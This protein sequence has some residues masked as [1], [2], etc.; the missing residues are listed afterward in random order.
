MGNNLISL[1][2]YLRKISERTIRVCDPERKVF[3]NLTLNDQGDLVVDTRSSEGIPMRKIVDRNSKYLYDPKE[4]EAKMTDSAVNKIQGDVSSRS[5]YLIIAANF[6]RIVDG[7]AYK[8]LPPIDRD[9]IEQTK[10]L[11][12]NFGQFMGNNASSFVVVD[13][14]RLIVNKSGKFYDRN[15]MTRMFEELISMVK[16]RPNVLS[17]ND[18]NKADIWCE[19]YVSYMKEVLLTLADSCWNV[20]SK[21]NSRP[22]E[23]SFQTWLNQVKHLPGSQRA[24]LQMRFFDEHWE[25]IVGLRRRR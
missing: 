10:C 8:Q 16:N 11:A 15:K 21:Y 3:W 24:Y 9:L 7:L 20:F 13:D 1:S 25:L 4:I 5:S 6:N 19:F 17:H 23:E 22:D 2:T 12:R 14:S 18:E